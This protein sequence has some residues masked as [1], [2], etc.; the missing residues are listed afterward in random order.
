MK[1]V[2]ESTGLTANPASP[3]RHLQ[4]AITGLPQ[5]KTRLLK[6]PLLKAKTSGSMHGLFKGHTTG[7]LQLR[8]PLSFHGRRDIITVIKYLLQHYVGVA[9]NTD[10]PH[11]H[12]N[13][14][15]NLFTFHISNYW[16]SPHDMEQVK[17]QHIKS[18]Q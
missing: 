12:L 5:K 9:V 4:H 16:L 2:S 14:N 17:Y 1:T 13:L 11:L 7:I 18:V 15:L 8:A 3:Y 10:I 6:T